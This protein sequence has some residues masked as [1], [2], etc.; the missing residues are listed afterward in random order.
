MQMIRYLFLSLALA[1]CGSH[2]RPPDL[3]HGPMP[4]P[5]MPGTA[6]AYALVKFL[7]VAG[8]KTA[9]APLCAI[10]TASL[11]DE[12]QDRLR[13][14]LRI[15]ND[16][17][18]RDFSS[19]LFDP[20]RRSASSLS[21]IDVMVR[22]G[23][24]WAVVRVSVSNPPAPTAGSNCQSTVVVCG[25]FNAENRPQSQVMTEC[26]HLVQEAD[27]WRVKKRRNVIPAAHKQEAMLVAD[28]VSC[29]YGN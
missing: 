19:P 7:A 17:R 6:D 27:K 21:I 5:L 2:R 1:A 8:G 20:L 11:N 13:K 10:G 24:A 3:T 28:V 23:E 25:G 22:P 15:D 26:L 16:C 9:T 29:P 12:Q 14:E 4:V 18:L